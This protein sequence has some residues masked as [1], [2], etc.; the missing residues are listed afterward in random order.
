MYNI[1]N[2]AV[3][4]AF[5]SFLLMNNIIYNILIKNKTSIFLIIFLT[6]IFSFNN[7]HIGL[8]IL[9][10]FLIIIILLNEHNVNYNELMNN[11]SFDKMKNKIN[12]YNENELE[13]HENQYLEQNIE[14]KFDSNIDP[15]DNII[16]EIEIEEEH[17]ELADSINNLT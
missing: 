6:I 15:I 10:I 11:F 4:F 12:L 8:L 1:I 14:S 9:S 16:N 13:S 17:N 2:I 7:I 5:I 3:I